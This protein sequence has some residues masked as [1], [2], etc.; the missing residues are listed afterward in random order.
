MRDREEGKF[1]NVVTKKRV[2]VERRSWVG[3]EKG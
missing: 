3:G 2:E 1:K